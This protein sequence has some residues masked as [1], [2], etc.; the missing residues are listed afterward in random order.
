MALLAM[1]ALVVVGGCGSGGGQVAAG[2]APKATVEAALDDLRA[3]D[4][5]KVEIVQDF[6][7]NPSARTVTYGAYHSPDRFGVYSTGTTIEEMSVGQVVYRANRNGSRVCRHHVRDRPTRRRSWHV[8]NR[9]F[10][11]I[12]GLTS[13]E[14]TEDGYRFTL[15]NDTSGRMTLR[16]GR[17]TE[18]AITRRSAST[19][20]ETFH[21]SM[22][23][24]APPLDPPPADQVTR[25]QTHEEECGL[26]P[27]TRTST[28]NRAEPAGACLIQP[29]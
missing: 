15:P 1:I 16:D 23:N 12:D 19:F 3:L 17:L 2:G 9:V 28:P 14:A 26:V 25:A 6:E 4:S 29:D 5:V 10:P 20:T 22:F 18:M 21:Y 27:T 8:A 7:A 13:V 24:A 11:N